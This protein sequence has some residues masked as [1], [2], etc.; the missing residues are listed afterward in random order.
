MLCALSSSLAGPARGAGGGWGAATQRYANVIQPPIFK[1]GS[2]G[3]GSDGG[4]FSGAS[5]FGSPGNKSTVFSHNRF[6]A[7]S[8][9]NPGDGFSDEEQRLF[10]C[11]AKD[12]ET[13]ES[14]RQWMFSCYSPMK[15]KPNVSGFQEFSPEEVRLEYYNCSANNNTENYINS[16][17]QLVQQWKNRLQELKALDASGRASLL[18]Q[19]KNVVT[20]PLPSLGFGGQQASSFGFPSFPVNSSSSAT[21]FSFK[22]N[23]SVPSGNA[24]AFGSSAAASNP[25]TFGATSSHSAPNPVGFG[26]SSAP[27]AASFSFKTSGT[28]SGSGTSGLSCFGN[29]A[30]ASSSST[31][32]LTV[33]G[34]PSTVTGNSHSG[35]N[36]TSAAQTASASGHNVTAMPS[37][38]L[39]GITSDKLYTP[40]SELTAE[41]LEQFEAKRFTL[42]KIPL[43]PP[44]IDLLYI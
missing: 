34:T 22:A 20:Q 8:G 1:H 32:P 12:M 33:S 25:P 21:S 18:S 15:D 36:N 28:T 11:I 14:S 35:A 40:R 24:P 5:G 19:L 27:S 6:S 13:W 9:A 38:V 23:P 37:A 7:L 31:A 16:V 17:G 3:G 4:G 43:K 10:D 42:G 41:E 39:N 29:S 2:W 30:A 44:P 26:N